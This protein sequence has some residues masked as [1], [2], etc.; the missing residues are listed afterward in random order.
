MGHPNR[1][2]EDGGVEGDLNCVILLAQADS[3]ERNCSMQPKD[4]S[5]NILVKNVAT[6]CPCLK[7]PFEVKVEI[8]I[9]CIDKGSLRKGQNRFCILV[10]CHEEHFDEVQQA[11]KGKTKSKNKGLPGSKIELNLC[12]RR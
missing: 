3:E 5:C 7:S 8:S 12:S 2:M 9:N 6:F 1:N 10:Y 11:W 4:C